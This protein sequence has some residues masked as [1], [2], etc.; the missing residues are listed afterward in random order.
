MHKAILH[1]YLVG[2]FLAAGAAKHESKMKQNGPRDM[3]KKGSKILP[4]GGGGVYPLAP[5]ER[6]FEVGAGDPA[7]FCQ[8]SAVPS[9]MI[10]RE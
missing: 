9:Q 8:H 5:Y 4:P 10:I 2:W 3:A 7:T 6:V 1:S